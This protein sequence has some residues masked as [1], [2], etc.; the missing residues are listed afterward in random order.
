MH[1]VSGACGKTV[2]T[3]TEEDGA[4]TI[5]ADPQPEEWGQ[6]GVSPWI[7]D[8]LAPEWGFVAPAWTGR[9]PNAIN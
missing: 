7:V 5:H 9:P 2:I 8:H 6:S 3:A 4:K 1:T